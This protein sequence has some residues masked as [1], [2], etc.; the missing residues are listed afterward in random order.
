M[1]RIQA[2]CPRVNDEAVQSTS[3]SRKMSLAFVAGAVCL[4]VSSI[5]AF[6]FDDDMPGGNPRVVYARPEANTMP[7]RVAYQERSNM[8]GGLI[9]FLFSGG[10]SGDPG[11]AQPRYEQRYEPSRGLP[12]MDP[13]YRQDPYGRSMQDRKSVV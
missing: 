6:A 10:Q 12:P 4:G 13:Q 3:M 8:G 2:R 11:Y 9:E 7:I 5:Q 1:D